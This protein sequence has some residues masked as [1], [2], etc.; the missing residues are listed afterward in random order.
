MPGWFMGFCCSGFHR[1]CLTQSWALV[2]PH[3]FLPPCPAEPPCL[4][5]FCGSCLHTLLPSIH[6]TCPASWTKLEWMC[7]RAS[8]LAMLQDFATPV[9]PSD[10]K[11]FVE[12]TDIN[13]SVRA[14]PDFISFVK[15][16]WWLLQSLLGVLVFIHFHTILLAHGQCRHADVRWGWVF[17]P[18]AGCDLDLPTYC[19]VLSVCTTTG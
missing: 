15:G 11:C 12:E 17:L 13:T 8:E 19:T 7:L 9:L 3:R 1:C 18:N 16:A 6:S 2:R 10:V 4:R 14:E 5:F